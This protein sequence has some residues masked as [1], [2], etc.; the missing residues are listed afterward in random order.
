[1][2]PTSETESFFGVENFFGVGVSVICLF[3]EKLQFTIY[4]YQNFGVKIALFRP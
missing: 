1:M 3:D 2:T 4:Q